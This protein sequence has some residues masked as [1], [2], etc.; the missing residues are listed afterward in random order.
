[1]YRLGISSDVSPVCRFVDNFFLIAARGDATACDRWKSCT[2]HLSAVGVDLHEAQNLDDAPVLALGWEWHA[3]AFYCPE[4]FDIQLRLISDW[5]SRSKSG[6]S[7]SVLEIE[8]LVGLLVWVSTAAPSIRPLVATT[9]SALYCKMRGRRSGP[10]FLSTEAS[11]AIV[12][13][14]SFYSSWDRSA[15]V[16]LGFSPSS[17]WEVLIRTDA[18]T[19]FG[20]G[21]FSFPLGHAF[22]H[23]WSATEREAASRHLRESSTFFELLAILI[24][25]RLWGPSLRQRR[26]QFESD[27]EP[28]VMALSKCYSP[29]PGCQGLIH[30]ICLA[31]SLYHISPRWEHILSPYNSIADALSHD[32]FP[33]AQCCFGEEFGGVLSLVSRQ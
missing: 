26:V 31:S 13:L 29:E 8:R 3:H 17:Q 21:G 15:P 24:A 7:F 1:M 18:S 9:R 30:E 28:A 27:S 19:D 22:I 5:L 16:V 25:L 23:E 14:H 11:A 2:D 10:I 32:S 12:L 33:Q 4:K 6:L 20:A